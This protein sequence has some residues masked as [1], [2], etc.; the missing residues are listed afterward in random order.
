MFTYI[1]CVRTDPSLKKKVAQSAGAVEYTDCTSAKG[2]NPTPNV[3]PRYD[4]K[5]DVEV[6]VMLELWEMRSTPLLPSFPGAL[7]PR[8]VAPNRVLS[9]GQK[10]TKMNYYINTLSYG[11]VLVV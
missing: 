4:T 10:R 7:W 5:L 6:P 11:G 2:V 1:Q 3:H 9:M 8:V